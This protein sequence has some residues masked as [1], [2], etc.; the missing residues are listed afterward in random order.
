MDID[1]TLVHCSTSPFDEYDLA[2]EIYFRGEMQSVYVKKRPFLKEF[3]ESVT[4]LFL[5]VIFTSA[6]KLYVEKLMEEIDEDRKIRHFYYR[7]ACLKVNGFFMKDLSVLANDSCDLSQIVLLDDSIQT[8]GYQLD[9][10]IPIIKFTGAKEDSTLST[11]VP[12]LAHLSTVKDVRPVIREKFRLHEKLEK[13]FEDSNETSSD[14][15][16]T[17]KTHIQKNFNFNFFLKKLAQDF[18]T[19]AIKDFAPSVFI[20]RE[21]VSLNTLLSEK[22]EGRVSVWK[23]TCRGSVVAIKKWSGDFS[24]HQ[25]SML[26]KEMRVLGSLRNPSICLFMG[27]FFSKNEILLVNESM[28]GNIEKLLQMRKFSLYEK[29]R[30]ARDASIGFFFN[31]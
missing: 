31:F 4:H 8:F 27:A 29:M 3:L 15:V 16:N 14:N 7:D 17:K 10:G 5:C 6:Q 20:P 13:S 12:F 28:E 22:E 18:F 9:N 21:H 26:E 1:Q 19:L 25:L 30:L 23:G 24:E 2:F 11:I